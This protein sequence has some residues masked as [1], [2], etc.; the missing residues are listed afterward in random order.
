MSAFI[1]ANGI[2]LVV[3][4]GEKISYKSHITSE[5][6][7]FENRFRDVVNS[8][9][10]PYWEKEIFFPD[11]IV[12]QDTDR[13]LLILV[14]ENG[15]YQFK[16]LEFNRYEISEKYITVSLVTKAGQQIDIKA[17]F[18]SFILTGNKE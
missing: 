3:K 2:A 17:N 4:A 9:E 6:E 14:A 12:Y 10:T 5:L 7:L 18:G 11:T 16:Y 13:S 8:L 15:I 1:L